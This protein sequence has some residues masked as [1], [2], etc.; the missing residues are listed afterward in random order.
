MR[1][2]LFGGTFNPIHRGHLH[3][4]NELSAAFPLDKVYL[5]PC[6]NPPHKESHGLAAAAD[7][8]EM[9]RLASADCRQMQVSD[10]ELHRNGP[11]YSID[12]INEFYSSHAE[13]QEFFMLVGSDAF[14]EL[15]TW[16]HYQAILESI[17][18]IVLPRPIAKGEGGVNHD[19]AVLTDFI[20]Q[21]LSPRYD[22][23]E[24]RSI[25]FHPQLMPIYH[26][27]K[28]RP[29]QISSTQ[30]RRR[31]KQGT[32]I[33]ELVPKIVANYIHAKGLYQ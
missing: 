19:H 22:F 30:V 33:D 15:D 32:S 29:L 28:L 4:A 3:I 12:T 24:G 11:S 13:G 25:Y 20:H 16:R 8:L 31:I 23:D 7:R 5:I 10:V 9:I 27:V 17:A 2:G 6:A 14:L 21:K 1:I 26:P 18:L